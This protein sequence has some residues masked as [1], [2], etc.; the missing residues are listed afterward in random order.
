VMSDD[1]HDAPEPEASPVPE[2]SVPPA[3]PDP[4]P[5]VAPAL[6]YFEKSLDDPP[7]HR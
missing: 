1:D 7:E 6:D 2:P 4:A 3:E 5:Y